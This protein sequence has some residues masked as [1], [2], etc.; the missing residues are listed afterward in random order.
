MDMFVWVCANVFA[1]SNPHGDGSAVIEVI[2]FFFF[3]FWKFWFR[4]DVGVYL[5]LS[6]TRLCLYISS[7]S[8]SFTSSPLPPLSIPYSIDFALWQTAVAFDPNPVIC[9]YCVLNMVADEISM[10]YCHPV[11]DS[12]TSV[13]AAV[14]LLPAASAVESDAAGLFHFFYHWIQSLFTGGNFGLLYIKPYVTLPL[15]NASAPLKWLLLACWASRHW[16][17]HAFPFLK[18]FCLGLLILSSFAYSRHVWHSRIWKGIL[19]N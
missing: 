8:P 18:G 2:F 3:F 13:C 7:L 16:I 10:H 19:R 11:A 14:S 9:L 17:S 6:T 12:S 15:S 5:F 4:Y 1:T